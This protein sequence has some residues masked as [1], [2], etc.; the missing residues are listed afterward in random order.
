MQ[1]TCLRRIGG[2]V[3]RVGEISEFPP[4]GSLFR[5]QSLRARLAMARYMRRNRS[6]IAHAFDFYTNLM[7]VPAARLAGV[8]VV[9]GSHRQLGDLLTPLQF[10]AQL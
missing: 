10:R 9:L 3:A 1:P 7:M 2:L 5:M 6:V 8:A 4:G